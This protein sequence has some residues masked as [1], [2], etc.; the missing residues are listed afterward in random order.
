M[1][2][3]DI[4]ELQVGVMGQLRHLVIVSIAIA[5]VLAACDSQTGARVPTTTGSDPITTPL[6]TGGS[7]TPAIDEHSEG[8]DEPD[9][10]PGLADNLPS[11]EQVSSIMDMHLSEEEVNVDLSQAFEHT[12]DEHLAE[13]VTAG[14]IGPMDVGAVGIDLAEY[15]TA[16]AA[17]DVYKQITEM[18]LNA[19]NDEG[20]VIVESLDGA[21]AA[22]GVVFQA[23]EGNDFVVTGVV[24]HKERVVAFIT[25]LSHDEDGR[26][27]QA[28]A[29]AEELF[30]RL[31][32]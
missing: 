6:G 7:P 14:F 19:D 24:I 26:H 3:L 21:D 31:T 20:R 30:R 9:K 4:K 12:E 22:T 11:I 25:V 2:V 27:E 10:L 8:A 5:L 29:L 1:P 15:T 16:E 17:S 23:S 18:G 28:G 32:Q 13:Y